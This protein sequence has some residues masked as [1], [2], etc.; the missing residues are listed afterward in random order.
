MGAALVLTAA[1]S[2]TRMGGPLKKEYL[3]IP[4]ETGATVLSTALRAFLTAHAFCVAVVTVPPGGEAGARAALDPDAELSAALAS[5]GARLRFVEGGLS[6]RESV[7]RALESL[8]AETGVSL[9]LVHDGARPWVAPDTI[10]SVLALAEASG[11]AAPALPAV[12]TLK[13]ID[14]EGTIVAHPS[15]SS[16]VAIQTPQG[17]R[18]PEILAA[19]RLAAADGREYTDD[20]EI[21]GRYRGPVR[22]CPG[23]PNNRKITYPGDLA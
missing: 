11:A 21:W 3:P 18:F 16:L 10:R 2:S 9:V 5:S 13:E 20:T 23:D 14:A 15:R 7:L 19:H 1:G 6:R 12:D 8:E 17:F 4:G 22:T